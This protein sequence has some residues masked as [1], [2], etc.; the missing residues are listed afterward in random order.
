MPNVQI[1]KPQVLIFSAKGRL[2]LSEHQALR[3][4]HIANVRYETAVSCLA[5]AELIS[6]CSSTQYLGLTRRTTKNFHAEIIKKLPLLKGISIYATGTEWVDSQFL[7]AKKIELQFL[8]SYCTLVVAEHSLAMLLNLSRRIHLS[9][10]IARGDLPKTISLRGW[11][12]AGKKIGIIG[13]GNIGQR[14]ALLAQAFGMEVAYYDPKPKFDHISAQFHRRDFKTLLSESDVLILAAS[15]DRMEPTIISTPEIILMKST[16]YIVNSGRAELVDR[17][18]MLQ[19]LYTK[20]VQGYA[21]DDY[22]YAPEQVAALENGRLLQTGHSAWYSNEAMER[23][24]EQWINHI[25]EMV[26]ND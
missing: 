3:L 14:V 1:E 12:L 26:E 13:M 7:A 25:I 22:V 19:A 5:D 8:E 18:A 2:S 20:K 16:V 21:V 4:E 9:D 17:D 10:R 6:L 24:T 15:M 23:G 11:E